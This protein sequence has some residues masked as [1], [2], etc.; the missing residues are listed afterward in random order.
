MRA[1]DPAATAPTGP[2]DRAPGLDRAAI[3]DVVGGGANGA[4]EDDR[5]AGRTAVPPAGPPV[6][7]PATTVNRPRG[8]GLDAAVIASR[9]LESGDA[10]VV[11]TGPDG[12][13]GPE[14]YGTTV[15]RLRERLFA[16]LPP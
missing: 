1:D 16:D 6:S 2:P 8:S 15:T 4:G 3:G 9:T 14:T 12:V 7:V 11:V 10:D 13:R 5:N